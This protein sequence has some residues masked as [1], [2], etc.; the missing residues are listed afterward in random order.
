VL[1]VISNAK[2]QIKESDVEISTTRGSGPGGQNKNKVETCVIV[3]HKKTGIVVRCETERS[4]Y[5][6]KEIA[7]QILQA[8]LDK[9][10]DSA[11]ST[12]MGEE[13]FRQVGLGQRGL[14]KVR[15][16]MEKGGIVIDNKTN[17]QYS[18]K[19]WRKGKITF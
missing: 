16:Y 7:F 12:A 10:Q 3:R 11:H 9:N 13:R 1:P 19:D 6:N 8:K 14:T 2:I 4:Q 18:L 17:T 15:T 5:Q